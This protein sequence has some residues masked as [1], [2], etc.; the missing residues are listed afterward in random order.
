L[1]AG[2]YVQAISVP[3]LL[4]LESKTS[5]RRKGD[6]C[7]F[8]T[9][10]SVKKPTGEDEA[11]HPIISETA[12]RIDESGFVTGSVQVMDGGLLAGRK[13]EVE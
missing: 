7:P 12:A 1:D 10:G 9:R 3:L 13:F 5:S 8:F 4:V 2:A 11:K 6:K